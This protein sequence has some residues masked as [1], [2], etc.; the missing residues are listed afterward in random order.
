MHLGL[1]LF[2]TARLCGHKPE[3]RYLIP[4]GRPYV[5]GNGLALTKTR[6]PVDSVFWEAVVIKRGQPA[7]EHSLSHN[8]DGWVLDPEVYAANRTDVP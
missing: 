7:A 1:H 2:V 5:D 8:I 3:S 6:C 4:G